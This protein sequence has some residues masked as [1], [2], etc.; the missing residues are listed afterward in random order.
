MS[1]VT[2]AFVFV[3]ISNWKESVPDD[4]ELDVV[5]LEG[6]E[7]VVGHRQIDGSICKIL[8]TSDG[9]LIAITK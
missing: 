1:S 7:K 2:Y 3:G 6:N 4:W 5:E 9:S 8:Q